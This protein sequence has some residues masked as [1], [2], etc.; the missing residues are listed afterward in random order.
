MKT[1]SETLYP[2]HYQSL[3][4]LLKAIHQTDPLNAAPEVTQYFQKHASFLESSAGVLPLFFLDAL[5]KRLNGD[6]GKIQ[7]LYLL[8]DEGQQIRMFN[9]MALKFP[10]VRIAQDILNGQY[11]NALTADD[12]IVILD[13]GIGTGQQIVRLIRLLSERLK[14]TPRITVIGIEPSEGSLNKAIS[15]LEAEAGTLGLSLNVIPVITTIEDIPEAEW[16]RV[17]SALKGQLIV[18]ASF[19]LHHIR[20]TERR[21]ELFRKVKKLKPGMVGIIEPYADFLTPDVQARFANA[22]HHYGLT[23]RAID[24]I[25]ASETEKR[26]LK[27]IFFSREIQ[28]VLSRDEL[29]VEQFETGEMWTERLKYAGFTVS[30][31]V[32]IPP[33]AESCPY[34]SVAQQTGYLGLT[35]EGHPIISIITAR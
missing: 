2:E 1:I 25:D 18:N 35:V 32:E 19:A 16:A 23:F 31:A 13:I 34:A 10:L 24:Q 30:D 9:F 12:E 15:A 26:D 14:P 17:Q 22:W 11:A 6:S 20:P 33:N 29:R 21:T 4:L 8:P 28:D 7:N 5:N 27:T 3:R